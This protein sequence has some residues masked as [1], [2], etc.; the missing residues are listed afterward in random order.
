MSA[1][2]VSQAL[3][4]Q[5]WAAQ[6]KPQYSHSACHLDLVPI[7]STHLELF[8]PPHLFLPLSMPF[9]ATLFLLLLLLLLLLT[10]LLLPGL[11]FTLSYSVIIYLRFIHHRRS[12]L[13]SAFQAFASANHVPWT[14]FCTLNNLAFDLALQHLH[15]WSHT[16]SAPSVSI[17]RT[18][19]SSCR[20]L[21]SLL[22][23]LLG[24]PSSISPLHFLK[25]PIQSN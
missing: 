12:K 20:Q 2:A 9:F 17:Q 11:K 15:G 5:T 25:V 13:F 22:V 6:E 16:L 23:P 18:L 1:I 3:L 21:V 14:N 8:L 19:L 10:T 7:I 4:H 24:T